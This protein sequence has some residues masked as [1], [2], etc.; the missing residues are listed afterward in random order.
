MHI[1]LRA[2]LVATLTALVIG[3]VG[4]VG[5]FSYSAGQQAVTT[6]A[7]RLMTEIG[8]RIEQRLVES[9][10]DLRGIVEINAALIQQGRLDVSDSSAF[11]RHFATQLGLYAGVDS[12]GLITEQHEFLMVARRAPNAL[13]IRRFNAATDYRLHHYRADPDG[14]QHDLIESRRNYD[15]HNDPPDRPWYP[16]ARQ[17]EQESWH[18]SVSL[19]KGQNRPELVSFYA[20]PFSDAAGTLQGVLV[21]GMTLTDISAFLQDLD[22]GASGQAFV[23][24]RQGM[25][26]ATSSGEIPFD[27]LARVDHAQ[28]VA[29]DP[30]RL[31]AAASTDAVTAQA[32]RALLAR[33]PSLERLSG[34]LGFAFDVDGRGYF[35]K[36]APLSADVGLPDWLILVVAPRDD[37]TPL[38]GANLRQPILSSGLAVLLAVLLGLAAAGAITRPLRQLGA[39]TRRLAE[40]DFSQPVPLA[41]IRELRDLGESFSAMTDRLRDAFA[42]LN[43][44]NQT[45]SAAEKALADQN[46]LLEQRVEERTAA[47]LSAHHRLADTIAQV[48]ASEAKFR[49]M[50]EQSPLGI[51]LVDPETGNPL[52]MN[53]RLLQ[54]VGRTREDV[55]AMGW[56]GITHPDDQPAQLEGMARLRAREIDRFQIE[57]RYLRPDGSHV[58]VDLRVASVDMG[59]DRRPVHLCLVEDIHARRQAEDALRESEE[60]F[61]A[62]FDNVCTAMC[63]VDLKGNLVQVNDEMAALFGYAK[64]EMEGMSVN[65]TALPEDAELSSGFIRDAIEGIKT[66]SIF[67]KRYRHRQGHTIHG[68]VAAS[69][70]CNARGEPAYFIS[71]I[72]DVSERKRYERHL[73]EAREAAEK[74]NAAKSDFLAHMT[75][76][77]RT[78]LHAILGF[79]EVLAAREHRGGDPV[80]ESRLDEDL[81]LL[82]RR[83]DLL[84]AIQRN[85][86]DLLALVNDVLDLSRMESGLLSLETRPT[87]LPALLR[88]CVAD[89]SAL[90][91]DKQLDLELDLDAKL[92]RG[93]QV[94]ARRMKQILNNLLGNAVK[95]TVRGRVVLEAAATPDAVN[96]DQVTLHIRVTDT[97]PG[98]PQSERET[99]FEVFTQGAAGPHAGVHRGSGLGLA[100]SRKLARQMGGEISLD[101]APDQGS[102]FTLALPGV[103]L[104]TL[105][106]CP[107]G[108]AARDALDRR[109]TGASAAGGETRD[110]QPISASALPSDA[111]LAELRELAEL[112][113][114]TRLEAWCEHWSAPDRRPDF[115]ADVLKL[116][117]AFAHERIIA[118]VD[119]S[120]AERSGAVGTAQRMPSELRAESNARE[121]S[122]S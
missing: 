22:V 25:L 29:V 35:A 91:K 1:S 68:V 11:D 41:P 54:I 36:A 4:A 23:V 44:V 97:G 70:V 65:D 52:E 30:R 75:H 5:L 108:T 64:H 46:R 63:L 28:N 17:A 66:T 59:A 19:A 12:I 42:K 119:A 120:R 67:E 99:I 78:P 114:T 15:P 32:A 101:S 87:D 79:A 83:G 115:A 92:P 47:L 37:F 74:A 81:V 24:D 45:L 16:E 80:A 103:P 76:E 26:V 14:R 118:L 53:E 55:L 51:V 18:I 43:A 122:A 31:A 71:Q 105:S 89:L 117:H 21:A 8:E 33:E 77:L 62:A 102:C 104:A 40:G 116:T 113:R 56:T 84:A 39:A 69:L 20:L 107:A 3:A 73:Q 82:R 61:R 10:S 98:I 13:M 111:A 9:L 109:G 88:E 38:I 96:A 106:D 7:V 85:G 90:A 112:G 34:P 72:Q 57:K 27:A 121:D 93:V 100:I 49:A 86:R 2:V 94:D 6:I 48:A 110:P 50:F 60:R 95:F 58:W